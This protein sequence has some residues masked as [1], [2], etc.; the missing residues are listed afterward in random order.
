MVMK[1]EEE[2][3]FFITPKTA[4]PATEQE[5]CLWT[6]CKELVLAFSAVFEDFWRNSPE[7]KQKISE[8]ESGGTA[9]SILLKSSEE[10][11]KTHRKIMSS[12]KKQILMLTSSQGL[13]T[14]CRDSVLT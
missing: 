2:I 6:D 1:D 9:Q 7:N 13:V 12:A 4:A 5:V 10:A 14:L 3:L 11:E 8:I